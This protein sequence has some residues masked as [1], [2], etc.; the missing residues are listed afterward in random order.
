[1]HPYVLQDDAYNMVTP[2]NAG[3]DHGY[4]AGGSLQSDDVFVF[5]PGS[6]GGRQ[7]SLSSSDI[8]LSL[9]SQESSIE[10][11]DNE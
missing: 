3:S 11:V 4:V 8:G 9:S 5:S 10:V 7:D 1:M 6:S 2:G